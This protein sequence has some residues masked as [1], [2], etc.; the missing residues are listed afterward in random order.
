LTK[1]QKRR[2]R[3]LNHVRFKQSLR[4]GDPLLPLRPL[5]DWLV[6][7]IA[8]AGGIGIFALMTGLD[9]RFIDKIAKGIVVNKSGRIER[10]KRIRLSVAERM[11]IATETHISYV[12]DP[13]VYPWLYSGKVPRKYPTLHQ[14]Q[15]GLLHA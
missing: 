9:P 7:A 8:E 12:W 13:D 14:R 2:R 10:Q 15:H 4:D 11:L 6:R 1:E 5:R 3:N